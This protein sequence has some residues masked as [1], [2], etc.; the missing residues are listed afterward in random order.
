[1]THL[2]WMNA[3]LSRGI[4]RKHRR[5]SGIQDRPLVINAI[6]LMAGIFNSML[7]F[8]EFRFKWSCSGL[9]LLFPLRA[10]QSFH[11]CNLHKCLLL[12]DN[13]HISYKAT[14]K[15]HTK[16]H[17][18]FWNSQY[19]LTPIKTANNKRLSLFIRMCWCTSQ[20]L[21]QPDKPK[22]KA[23][24]GLLCAYKRI[25]WV[26]WVILVEKQQFVHKSSTLH[27]GWTPYPTV[28]HPSI[29][30]ITVFV[31]SPSKRRKSTSVKPIAVSLLLHKN[32]KNSILWNQ[33]TNSAQETD[34]NFN[35]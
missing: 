28:L 3:V 27:L 34:K 1:M 30:L 12:Q 35:R 10:S 5:T 23:R 31:I 11:V 29:S 25:C 14:R 13:W 20:Y 2:Y 15:T 7:F 33:Q 22:C 9:E 8:G 21:L 26:C 6:W 16:K 19:F 4:D 32:K 17:F 24:A 18:S